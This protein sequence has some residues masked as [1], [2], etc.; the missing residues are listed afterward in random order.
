MA[1]IKSFKEAGGA[2]TLVAWRSGGMASGTAVETGAEQD[3]NGTASGIDN[4]APYVRVA[5]VCAVNA[6]ST[7]FAEAR[8]ERY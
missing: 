1:V 4:R 7:R 2:G 8:I 3:V 5:F 6:F